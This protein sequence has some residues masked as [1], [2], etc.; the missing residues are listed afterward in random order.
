MICL[1]K[2]YFWNLNSFDIFVEYKYVWIDVVKK[3]PRNVIYII[4]SY[5]TSVVI[6]FGMFDQNCDGFC[7]FVEDETEY[8]DKFWVMTSVKM[9]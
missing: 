6:H 5:F 9:I 3:D 8:L 7:T 4:E 2:I 1:K